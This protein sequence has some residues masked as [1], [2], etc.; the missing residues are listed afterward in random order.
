MLRKYSYKIQAHPWIGD[1]LSL[2]FG[3]LLVFAFAPYNYFP[4]A[5]LSPAILFFLWHKITPLRA[6]WRGWLYGIG[7]FGM[8]VSWLHI[9]LDQFGGIGLYLA[10]G[11]TGLFVLGLATY[12]GLIG[13]AVIRLFPKCDS[14]RLLFVLPAAWVIMEW[15]RSWLFSGFP[16]LLLGYSQLDAP[17]SGFAPLAGVYGVSWAAAFSASLLVYLAL[18]QDQHKSLIMGLTLAALWL[19]GGA[20]SFVKWSNPLGDP[21]EVAL[22]QGNIAQ[23]MKFAHDHKDDITQRYLEMSKKHLSAELIVWP[24]TAIP[25]FYHRS[26]PI[27][28]DIRKL[29]KENNTDFVVG[30]AYKD[31]DENQYNAAV[32]IDNELTTDRFYYKQHLVPFGEYMPFR[33][34]LEVMLDFIKIPFSDFTAGNAYQPLFSVAGQHVVS[35][36]ICYEDAFSWLVRQHAKHSSFLINISNDGW[37]GDSIAASQ[38]L[39]IARMRAL[40]TGRFLLRSTNTGISAIINSEGEIVQQSNTFEPSVLHGQIIPNDKA[41]LYSLTGNIPLLFIMFFAIGV[42]I[43]RHYFWH[44]PP[45]QAVNMPSRY[46]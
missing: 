46:Q 37:F 31:E 5:I 9:S 16:W 22:V 28:E 38:H 32:L 3:G 42:G 45:V 18:S 35:T 6:F 43:I 11:L 1:L 27:I 12:I 20:L 41:T 33:R 17:L 25:D 13:W 30:I 36:S 19:G 39:Q 23:E 10:W 34:Y 40:E 7:M 2:L 29:A 44:I 26:I 24:E 15:L 21:I 4:L 8:G 14:T